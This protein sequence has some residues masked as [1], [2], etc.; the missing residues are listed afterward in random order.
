MNLVGIIAIL[1]KVGATL[2]EDGLQLVSSLALLGAAAEHPHPP[3]RLL[4]LKHSH[5]PALLLPASLGQPLPHRPSAF[6]DIQ[7]Q[8]LVAGLLLVDAHEQ[9]VI[10]ADNA[11]EGLAAEVVMAVV[12]IV[13]GR[14]AD[15]GFLWVREAYVWRE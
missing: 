11:L 15:A 8:V 10:F 7:E 13:K 1:R 4:Q 3:A 14:L 5:F 2:P 6:A 12:H 9:P